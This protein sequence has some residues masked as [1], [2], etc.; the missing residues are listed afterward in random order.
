MSLLNDDVPTEYPPATYF[1]EN[2]WQYDPRLDAPGSSRFPQITAEDMM[3]TSRSPSP[4]PLPSPSPPPSLPLDMSASRQV[5]EPNH[6]EARRI[7]PQLES[8]CPVEDCPR[9]M[10]SGGHPFIDKD[11]MMFH[12]HTMHVDKTE[13]QQNL[14]A[15]HQT[16]VPRPPLEPTTRVQPPQYNNALL[17]D[18]PERE[19]VRPS[20]SDPR[21]MQYDRNGIPLLQEH[22]RHTTS[23]EQVVMQWPQVHDSGETE[24]PATSFEDSMMPN[25]SRY[26]LQPIPRGIQRQVNEVG[27]STDRTSSRRISGPEMASLYPEQNSTTKMT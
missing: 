27:N 8:W 24:L 16:S 10:Q 22:Q 26:Y 1:P 13:E 21:A 19:N 2:Q 25:Q 20:F 12:L 23:E 18:P 9:S 4:S 3:R 6:V 11:M 14:P 15:Q 17:A 7:L 5:E